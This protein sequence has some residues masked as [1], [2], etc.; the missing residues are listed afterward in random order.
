MGWVGLR[1]RALGDDH[2]STLTNMYNL[3]IVL[4]QQGKH[5]EAK[6]QRNK[7]K[8]KADVKTAT[9]RKRTQEEIS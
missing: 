6:Q 5:A 1:E 2:P 7:Y 4:R 3:A 9:Q 8:L